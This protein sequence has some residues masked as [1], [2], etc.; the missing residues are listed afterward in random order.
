MCRHFVAGNVP[1]LQYKNPNVQF[2]TFKNVK[3]TPLVKVFF[4]ECHPYLVQL[5]C[6][7]HGGGERGMRVEVLTRG[8]PHVAGDGQKVTLDVERKTSRQIITELKSVAAKLE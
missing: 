5:V 7:W 3:P 6:V 1:Q 4:G 2:L 8:T